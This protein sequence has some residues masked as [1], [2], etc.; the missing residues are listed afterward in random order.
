ML[1][2]LFRCSVANPPLTKPAIPACTCIMQDLAMEN[3]KLARLRKRRSAAE[4]GE[5][6]SA[7]GVRKEMNGAH[8]MAPQEL[9]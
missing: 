3:A 4:H 9:C 6:L 8:G 5:D 2:L 7:N 1:W